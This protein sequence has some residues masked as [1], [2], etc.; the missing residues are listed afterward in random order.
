MEE[1]SIEEMKIQLERAK[2]ERDQAPEALRRVLAY[3][4]DSGVKLAFRHASNLFNIA[5]I[6]LGQIEE[7]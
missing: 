7:L 3:T 2:L 5:S 1:I 6:G 4:G